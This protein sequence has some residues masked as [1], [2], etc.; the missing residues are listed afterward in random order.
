MD[1]AIA[2]L[3]DALRQARAQPHTAERAEILYLLGCAHLENGRATAARAHLEAARAAYE[4]CGN[5]RGAANAYGA[6]GNLLGELGEWPAA[7]DAH[8]SAVAAARAA[9]DRDEESLQLS[10]LAYACRR[11]GQ[12]GAAVRSYRQALHLAYQAGDQQAIAR[13]AAELAEIL[14]MSERHLD[15]A[16]LLLVEAARAGASERADFAELRA[17]LQQARSAATAAGVVQAPVRGDAA[18]YARQA[19]QQATVSRRPA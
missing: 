14:M 5:P 6:L 3:Q 15:I 10:A 17:A 4:D 1:A 11:S 7:A 18:A 13:A 9:A 8:Q 2:A 16:A 12:P 19:Y